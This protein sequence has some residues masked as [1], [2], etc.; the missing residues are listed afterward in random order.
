MILSVL[1]AANADPMS[2]DTLL[3]ISHDVY[4]KDKD[5]RLKTCRLRL[6]TAVAAASNFRA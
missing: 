4:S 3:R 1:T 6:E 5:L 2:L